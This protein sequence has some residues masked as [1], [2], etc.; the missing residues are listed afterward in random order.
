[1]TTAFGDADELRGSAHAWYM[2]VSS[3]R[4][5]GVADRRVSRLPADERARYAELQTESARERYLAARVLCRE[6][7][8]RYTGVDPDLWR[9]TKGSWGK[10]MV[11]QPDGFDALRFNVSSA[12]DLVICIVTRAGEV[13]VDVE[14]T[15]R[16]VDASLVARHF[17]PETA[18]ARISAL[19]AHE[20][21]QRFFEQWILKEA[22]V[23]ATGRG[24]V[25]TDE[26]FG[27]E[28]DEDGTPI[29]IAGCRFSLHRLDADCVA[30]AA[31]LPQRRGETIRF[32]W[33]AADGTLDE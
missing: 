5:A 11:A 33:L 7:L 12:A 28:Q 31:V 18:S 14:D 23:K 1:M 8:S 22:Y 15:T 26:R 4:S 29:P 9:F 27:V 13:G 19:P 6:T 2:H 10:P 32:Q 16:G 20:R 3:F 30:A 21:R 17:L 24:L 25:E